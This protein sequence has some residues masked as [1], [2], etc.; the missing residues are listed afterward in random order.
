MVKLKNDSLTLGAFRLS[1]VTI[2]PLRPTDLDALTQI[3]QSSF[4]EE[5]T[6]RGITPVALVQQV[7]QVTRGRMIP[8]KVLAALSGTQWEMLVAE[9]DGHVVGCGGYFGRQHMELA[10]LMVMPNYRRRGIGQ[11]LLVK[12]L[13]HLQ[14]KGYPLATTTIL[15]TNEASLGNVRK[16][17]FEAFDQYVILEKA[18]PLNHSPHPVA[19]RPIEPADLAAFREI[20]RQS[21]APIRLEIQGSAAPDYFPGLGSRLMNRLTGTE[22]WRTA[23]TH[24]GAIVGFML[25]NTS[26]NQTKGI[27]SRPMIPSERHNHLPAMLQTAAT[28]LTQLRKTSIQ[29]AISTAHE[30]LIEG[31]RA[32]GWTQTQSWL[33]L[34]KRLQAG[35]T[36]KP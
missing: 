8:F 35:S 33:R 4:A 3:A 27:L 15:A 13:E 19:A 30:D 14:A 34:V 20:E 21:V 23:F 32:D 10:N 9:I 18:L 2:R 22:Q 17:G 25:G 24:G 1:A 16:Q 11:A 5:Y 6:A 31:M 29:I 36:E 7:R 12:R 28:W 26:K